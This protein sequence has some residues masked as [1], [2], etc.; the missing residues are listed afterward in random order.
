MLFRRLVVWNST[1]LVFLT[2][3]FVWYNLTSTQKIVEEEVYNSFYT[4]MDTGAAELASVFRDA[5]NLTLEL[6]ANTSVQRALRQ[7]D[8]AWQDEEQKIQAARQSSENLTRFFPTFNAEIYG[9]DAEHQLFGADN[10]KNISEEWLQAV[11]HAQGQFVWDY[12][13]DEPRVGQLVKHLIH[14]E[15]LGLSFVDICRDGRT[16]LERIEQE[17][18]EV[19]ITDI[20]MPVLTGLELVQQVSERFPQTRF[21]VISGY[22]YFEYA[23]KA[24]K[25]GV[26]DYLLKPIDEEELNRTLKK[27]CDALQTTAVHRAQME[28]YEKNY[29]NSQKLLSR[30]VMARLKEGYS[31]A[32]LPE[33]NAA[34]GV[35]FTGDCFMAVVLRVNSSLLQQASAEEER[36]VTEKVHANIKKNLG[37]QMYISCTDG[38]TTTLLLNFDSEA[39][40]K[41]DEA[42]HTCRESCRSYMNNY[43]NYTVS[44]G[45]SERCTEVAQIGALLQQAERAECRKLFE[46]SGMCLKYQAEERTDA[47]RKAWQ[48]KVRILLENGMEPMQKTALQEAVDAIFDS[49]G[50]AGLAAWEYFDTADQCLRDFCAWSLGHGMEM[51]QDWVDSKREEVRSAASVHQLAQWLAATLCD[52]QEELYAQRIHTEEYPIRLATEYMK[53]HYADKITLEEVAAH[54]GFNP[55]YFSEKFKEKTGK[56]FT[57]SLTEIRMEAAKELLRDSRKTI[58]QIGD[59]V[60][61]KDA[62]YFSQQFTKCVGM[63]PTEYRKL[64]Y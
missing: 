26:E 15:E 31:F 13:Y 7:D 16:A 51:R 35:E 23:Q 50:A 47:A 6:C 19:V 10:I 14:W 3:V 64:Y 4:S 62:K 48:N 30:D 25:Y 60:G 59:A 36:L 58:G 43:A 53:K 44:M 33:F 38:H 9:L 39:Y 57:D 8:A 56:N 29:E 34:A 40:A 12:H 32:G 24:L 18:P 22:R 55:T 5:R 20:R 41:T 1:I 54:S 17:Q 42:L 27:I 2:A 28:K 63:K 37:R 45:Q 61:Y 46:G 11:L 21:V 52:K 49:A